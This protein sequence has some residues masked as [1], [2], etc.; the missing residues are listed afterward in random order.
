MDLDKFRFFRIKKTEPT[1]VGSIHVPIDKLVKLREGLNN[2]SSLEKDGFR[3]VY[4]GIG[5]YKKEPAAF[6]LRER[7]NQE[8][9]SNN[10][11]TGTLNIL[12]R[13]FNIENWAISF[14]NFD[15]PENTEIL[16]GLSY[17]E[18]A[19]DI[20]IGWRLEFGTPILCRQ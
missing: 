12:N 9:N 17:L 3:V 6:G 5:G 14:F 10:R 2:I 7:I 1:E 11:R 20:E 15:D 8:L 19:N 13:G 18:N 16:N 4:N